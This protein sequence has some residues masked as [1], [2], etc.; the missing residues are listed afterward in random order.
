[1]RDWIW[2]VGLAAALLI[3]VVVNVVMAWYAVNNPPTIVESY[4]TEA[5]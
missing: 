5:R 1:M 2:P 3:V 4:E